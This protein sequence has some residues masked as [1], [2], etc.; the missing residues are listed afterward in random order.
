MSTQIPLNSTRRALIVNAAGVEFNAASPAAAPNIRPPFG[1]AVLECVAQTAARFKRAT[2]TADTASSTNSTSTMSDEE[3]ETRSRRS[4]V[5]AAS[6]G[7]SEHAR[8][9]A[10][11]Q[12]KI[13]AAEADL[14][15]IKDQYTE[16]YQAQRGF[17]TSMKA[18]TKA[19]DEAKQLLLSRSAQVKACAADEDVMATAKLIKES[20]H[21]QAVLQK[22]DD[23]TMTLEQLHEYT[24]RLMQG[25]ATILKSNDA[26][27]A[28]LDFAKDE[29]ARAQAAFESSK[30]KVL[31][32]E[33]RKKDAEEKIGEL[34]KQHEDLVNPELDDEDVGGSPQSLTGG[35][36]LCSGIVPATDLKP[37]PRKR[38]ATDGLA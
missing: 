2:D 35:L 21:V 18:K 14:K 13:D 37:P 8:E 32:L 30:T 31:D 34:K 38:R 19:A 25:V 22:L 33:G 3:Q 36:S 11:M 6:S 15:L 1:A 10:A 27:K 20:A 29:A 7:G 12:D 23:Q 26:E 17:S 9:I 16:A 28:A 4:S 5:S 24:D